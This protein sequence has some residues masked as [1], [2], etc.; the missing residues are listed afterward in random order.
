MRFSGKNVLV[1]GSSRGIGA[2][3]AKVLGSYGLKVWV[4]YRSG[5]E[6]A[7]AVQCG[8][9]DALRPLVLGRGSGE[10]DRDPAGLR[11]GH[12]HQRL[13]VEEQRHRPAFQAELDQVEELDDAADEILG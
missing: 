9:N 4:H 3:I 12:Q 13:L 5:A 6:A 10:I 1:T 8:P 7:E 2:E 11:D